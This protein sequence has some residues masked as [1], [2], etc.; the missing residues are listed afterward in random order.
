MMFYIPDCGDE[1]SIDSQKFKL[2]ML[3]EKYGGMVTEFHEC[4]TY[5]I[6]P[7]SYNLT[8]KHFFQGEVYSARWLIESVKEG[9]LLDRGE[10]FSFRNNDETSKRLQF[11]KQNVKYTI[12]E[13]IKIYKIAIP[14]KLNSKSASF[15]VNVERKMEL[16]NRTADSLRNFWKTVE[17]KGLEHH[18]KTS[19]D[20]DTRYCHAFS[21]IPKVQCIALS[22]KNKWKDGEL[23]R[24]LFRIADDAIP[25][26]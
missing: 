3:I 23:E 12:T 16:P 8:H 2:R 5:Q 19:L 17:K 24:D 13:A 25:L 18:M 26:L 6:E 10:F 22:D 14:N 11:G 4:F 15:W 21:K 20:S 1:G 9:M 7:I